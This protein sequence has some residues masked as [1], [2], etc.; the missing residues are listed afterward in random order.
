MPVNVFSKSKGG[1]DFKRDPRK[2]QK[3]LE[4]A[5]AVADARNYDYAIECYVN[6]LKHDPE[7]LAAHQALRDVALRRKVGGGKPA[8]MGEKLKSGGS[9]PIDK[10]LHAEM[11]WS[12]DPLNARQ[13]RDVMKWAVES[14]QAD[15]TLNLGEVVYWVG[16]MVLEANAQSKKP[17]K[18]VYLQ[19]R[20]LFARIQAFDKAVEACKLA[21]RMD[22]NS[23]TLRGELKNLEAERTMHE[24]GYSG[25]QKVESGGFRN[26]VRDADKQRALEQDD[27]IRKTASAADEMIVRR[28][29]ELEEDPQDLDRLQ[30]LIDALLQKEEPATEAEAV[31]LL[32]QTW[33]QTGQYR[34][35]LRIGD[36]RMKQINR[37]Q[38]ELKAQL[39]E[40][41]DP[42][43]RKKFEDLSRKRLAF[44]LQEFA[45]RAKHYPTDMG[46][47][48]ELGKRMY[49]AK[50]FDDAIGAFQQA[51][52]DPK[53]RAT[54]H[55]FLGSCYLQKGWFEEAIDTL[56]QGIE[57]HPAT[58][59]RLAMDL[60]YLLMEALDRS[61]RKNSN[62]E[63]AKEAQKTA[64]QILQT[65]INYRDIRER[66]DKLRELV[67]SM[68]AKAAG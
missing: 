11:L 5:E 57:A 4:H 7:N 13:M 61:A 39:Q 20:D 67:D 40:I 37:K 43:L 17:D 58:D 18:S 49:Q 41:D 10:M 68:P 32:Q 55:E 35:K 15:E 34:Y 6:G 31:Q 30:K 65:D 19:A 45:E 33:D 22:P 1:N 54:S 46:L 25:G 36:I 29:A 66:M 27:A 56:R 16:T 26:F 14:D 24:G 42:D 48:F 63:Q 28:R 12:K 52:A 64:S 53:H 23:D 3:F 59:D 62:V 9:S 44:E 60:R 38:R 8:G 50:Q 2:A 51:K 47:K 21:L